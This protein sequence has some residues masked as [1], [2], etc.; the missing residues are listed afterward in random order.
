MYTYVITYSPAINNC[1]SQIIANNVLFIVGLCLFI[2]VL[3][4]TAY[5]GLYLYKMRGISSLLCVSKCMTNILSYELKRIIR[6]KV[7]KGHTSGNTSLYSSPQMGDLD[8]KKAILSSLDRLNLILSVTNKI[9]AVINM[10]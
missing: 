6:Q 1:N 7:I 9:I 4:N 8:L 5:T 10:M 3:F 2:Y